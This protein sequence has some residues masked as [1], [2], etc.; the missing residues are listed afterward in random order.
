MGL[1][2]PG[3]ECANS[4]C[5]TVTALL[6][7]ASATGRP[8]RAVATV[9]SY[10]SRANPGPGCRGGVQGRGA[11]PGCRAGVQGRGPG[12]VQGRGVGPGH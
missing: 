10:C 3:M 12:G 2:W 11:G 5:L 7:A 8:G 9:S 6:P 1:E 4:S